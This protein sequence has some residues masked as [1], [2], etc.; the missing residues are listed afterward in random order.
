MTFPIERYIPLTIAIAFL[1][2]LNGCEQP[3]PAMPARTEQ[4]AVTR[5]AE[6]ATAN[7][8]AIPAADAGEAEP[9]A[10][11]P[12]TE[13]ATPAE[14]ADDAAAKGDGDTP[15][16]NRPSNHVMLGSP[17]L[18]AGIPGEG[19]LKT[20]EIEA[21]LADPKNH[22]V[23]EIE[24]PVGLSAGIGQVKGL[25]NNPL[26]RAKIELGRQ[27]YFDPR[28]S[29]TGADVSC[30][31]CHDPSEGFARHTQFG[32]GID[33]KQGT[34]NSPVSYNRI[35]SDAQFWD[36]RAASLE[37]QAKGPIANP[38][39]MGNTHEACVATLKGIK[40]YAL[41]FDRVFG[42]LDI[43]TVAQAI[44]AFE[45]TLV[46]GPAPFDYY[47]RFRPMQALDPDDLK[48][49]DPDLYETYQQARADAEKHPMSESAKRGRD[50]FF[51]EKGNCTACH[52]GPNLSDEQ[53]HNLGVGMAAEKPDI[54]REEVTR[55]E[56]DRGAFKTPTIRNVAT[57]A[58]YMHDGSQE[59]L[60]E[61]V[62]WYDK[63]GHPNPH[64]SDKIKKLNLSEQD[65]ADLVA[66]MEACTGE[67]PKVETGRLPE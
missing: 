50:I 40:G 15:G 61:V 23:L 1:V 24:L 49:D 3:K 64:L 65:K 56:K 9:A 7:P 22:E 43:D 28:L 51:T 2:A 13:P 32:I 66:F 16:D 58:P 67:F 46:T 59:T 34:R 5:P 20:A 11:E 27:L 26:T 60:A 39:E 47:E 33:G 62:E 12:G 17:E 29:A 53:Y 30:A 57:S 41:Q 4:A 35:L 37:D 48:E 14:P 10:E 8:T 38:I 25:E 21:W 6:P 55:N 63:G 36:G 54:G 19:S 44:A 18:T 31:S 42:K 52:V 45:R